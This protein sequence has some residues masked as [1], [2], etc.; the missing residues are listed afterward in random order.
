MRS[1]SSL[2][3]NCAV[4]NGGEGSWWGGRGVRHSAR[5]VWKYERSCNS[6]QLTCAV[7]TETGQQLITDV[8]LH[9]HGACMDLENVCSALSTVTTTNNYNIYNTCRCNSTAATNNCTMP[10]NTR[11]NSWSTTLQG[12]CTTVINSSTFVNVQDSSTLKNL[13][14]IFSS[15]L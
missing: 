4:G 7:G 14:V 11:S 15:R 10:K 1:Y 3:L 6:L 12:Q 13:Q 9:T 2:Q 8:L 5:P